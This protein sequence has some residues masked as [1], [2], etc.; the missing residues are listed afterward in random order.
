MDYHISSKNN[1]SP[2]LW[3]PHFW[4]VF[5]ITAFGYPDNPNEKDKKV[6]KNFYKNFANILPC[7]KCSEDSRKMNEFIVWDS[8][9]ENRS[10]LIKWTYE[11]H[12]SV[13]LKL[14][15]NSPKFEDFMKNFM[16]NV[17]NFTCVCNRKLEYIIIISLMLILM[18]FITHYTLNI[19]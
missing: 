7:N 5:H 18:F 19:L 6:Y 16:K 4:K 2:K 3:G 8:V 15:K 9:L 1:I 10:S 11:Y 17:N 12:D 13:N 14:G